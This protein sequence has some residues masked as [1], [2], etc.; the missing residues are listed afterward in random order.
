M[1][2]HTEER[3]KRALFQ[4]ELRVA[5]KSIDPV[6]K[7]IAYLRRV[8]DN[9]VE[10]TP[11]TANKDPTQPATPAIDSASPNKVLD[12]AEWMTRLITEFGSR[13]IARV[14]LAFADITEL[15]R[16]A[17]MDKLAET[18]GSRA[19][20]A[21]HARR[22][23]DRDWKSPMVHG[24]LMRFYAQNGLSEVWGDPTSDDLAALKAEP[25]PL[26]SAPQ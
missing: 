7:P 17:W 22:L 19:G 16:A 20:F 23:K 1:K 25:A 5:N 8:L 15:E 13:R 12:A 9:M 26:R 10:A 14:S 6:G 18:L 11:E 3:V 24:Q 2:Q 4:L 21:R